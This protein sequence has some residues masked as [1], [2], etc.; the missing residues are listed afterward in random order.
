[1]TFASATQFHVYL[2]WGQCLFSIGLNCVFN[3]KA[4]VGT[5]NKEKVLV[6]AFSV[7]YNFTD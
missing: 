3:V 1:M 7:I 6:G 2:T 5:F 4:L